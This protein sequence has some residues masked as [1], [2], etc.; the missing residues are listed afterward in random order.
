MPSL[1]RLFAPAWPRCWCSDTPAFHANTSPAT[2]GAHRQNVD[3]DQK[4][5]GQ[6]IGAGLHGVLDRHAPGAASKNR[7]DAVFA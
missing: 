4:R 5:L 6:A 7:K 1:S 2:A 3:T